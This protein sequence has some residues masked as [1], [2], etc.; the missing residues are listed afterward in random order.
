MGVAWRVALATGLI[1][2]L[3]GILEGLGVTELAAIGSHES[4]WQFA[5]TCLLMTI[6]FVL[7]DG[8]TGRHRRT[9]PWD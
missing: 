3:L 1:S 9:H 2:A 8:V 7:A 5:N 6:A 4:F